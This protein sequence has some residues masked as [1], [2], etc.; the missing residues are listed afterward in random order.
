MPFGNE[1][2]VFV[3]SVTSTTFNKLKP[4]ELWVSE[5][6]SRYLASE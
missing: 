1:Q 5:D 2:H 3:L 6:S 4:F